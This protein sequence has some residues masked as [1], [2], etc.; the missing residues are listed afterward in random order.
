MVCDGVAE[1]GKDDYSGDAVV[2][3][4]GERVAGV[5]VE[6]A[7]DF[8]VGLVGEPPVGEVGLPAF[9]GLLGGEA[10]VG[11]TRAL[12][13]GRGDQPGCGQVTVDGADRDGG[14][15][16]VGRVPGDGLGPV[17]E[18][19]VGQFGAQSHDELDVGFG[20]A[21][22]A[23]VRPPGSGLEGGLTLDP[24]LEIQPWETP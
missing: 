7:Q 20:Q 21:A 17:V 10:D 1:L 16:V 8:G 18:A 12:L 6:P 5:V 3:G 14:A 13:R 11:R 23:G 19:F 2:G 9:I 15:V 4:D 24:S 22:R